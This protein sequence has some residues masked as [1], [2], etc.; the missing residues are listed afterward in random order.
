MTYY[1][2]HTHRIPARTDGR[3]I[4]NLIVG[5]EDTAS[6]S[7]W[8]GPFSCGIH[9]WYIQ[10]DPSLQLARLEELAGRPEVVAIGEAGLDRLAS[11][12]MEE[13]EELFV[14]QAELAERTGKPLVIHCVRAWSELLACHRRIKPRVPWVAH[15]FRGK[16]ELAAR[17]VGAGLYLSFG[18]RL[19]PAAA[20]VAWPGRILAETDDSE[21]DIRAVYRGLAEA[22]GVTGESLAR[23]I[24]RNAGLFGL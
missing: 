12:T 3:A 11:A 14:A 20:K 23:E 8:A 5:R 22:L 4:V 17:L 2:I 6:P 13:Q 18:D 1:D 24:A 19:N 15:G 21:V 10:R 7:G 9:P 16:P